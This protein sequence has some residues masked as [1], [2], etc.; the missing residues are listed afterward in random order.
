[1]CSRAFAAESGPSADPLVH[2][3]IVSK[4]TTQPRPTGVHAIHPPAVRCTTHTLPQCAVSARLCP[5]QSLPHRSP[6]AIAICSVVLLQSHHN[7]PHPRNLQ[8][9]VP[10]HAPLSSLSLG[11]YFHPSAIA[12]SISLGTSGATA[13]PIRLSDLSATFLSTLSPSRPA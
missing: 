4:T 12:A 1:M 11:V 2:G 5:R 3:R 6:W 13:L 10:A 7:L 8:A 9:L